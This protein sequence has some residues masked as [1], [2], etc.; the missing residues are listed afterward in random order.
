MSPLSPEA[1]S[2]IG[3]V[4]ARIIEL[5]NVGIKPELLLIPES[6]FRELAEPYDGAL[7]TLFGVPT[8]GT[9]MVS[10]SYVCVKATGRIS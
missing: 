6:T 9:N 7:A 10:E 3:L 1:V 5:E 4:H 2:L 8:V